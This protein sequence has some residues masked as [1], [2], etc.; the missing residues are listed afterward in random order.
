[1]WLPQNNR[2]TLQTIW[3]ASHISTLGH[4]FPAHLSKANLLSEYLEKGRA[5][6]REGR[7]RKSLRKV[8]FYYELHHYSRRSKL[9]LKLTQCWYL[10]GL[11]WSLFYLYKI[12]PF[13]LPSRERQNKKKMRE[14]SLMRK[15]VVT[16]YWC[17]ALRVSLLFFSPSPFIRLTFK[18][19]ISCFGG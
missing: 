12:Q 4:C 14:I 13:S 3:F 1:M 18:I 10:L 9:K 15:E 7:E 16:L 11:S 19:Y 2:F 6:V 8:S 5:R 17:G